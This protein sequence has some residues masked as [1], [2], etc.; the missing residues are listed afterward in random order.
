[1]YY[2]IYGSYAAIDFIDERLMELLEHAREKNKQLGVTGMLYYFS[3]QFIQLIEGEQNTIMQLAS[4]I[5][6]DSRHKYFKVMKE[7]AID[8]RF[9]K[10]WSMGF[11]AINP[12]NFS[13]IDSF[14]DLN[15]TR[16]KSI[17]SVA[18][19]MRILAAR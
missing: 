7:G 10:E 6:T 19:L 13:E 11:K 5:A 1:M 4:T 12:G 2:L 17:E 15:D 14:L 9:F 16:G 8:K 18:H 3:G